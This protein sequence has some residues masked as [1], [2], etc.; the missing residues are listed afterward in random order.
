MN[1]R[2]RRRFHVSTFRRTGLLAIAVMVVLGSS[3]SARADVASSESRLR[4]TLVIDA[5]FGVPTSTSAQAIHLGARLA[6]RDIERSADLDDVA[7]TIRTTD[8][9]G[10]SAIGVDNFIDAAKD[11]SVIAVMG[12]KLSP[13]QIEV[14]A[15]AREQGLMLLDP[16]GAADGVIDNGF[17]PNWAFR[18]SMKDEWASAAFVRAALARG[19]KDVGVILHNS[20]WGRSTQAALTAQ[21]RN[22][23]L[24]IVGERWFNW[25]AVSLVQ[26]YLDLVA[27]GAQLVILVAN[28]QEG[29]LLAR[30]VA[31]L[32]AD[33]RRPILSHWGVTGGDLEKLA[34]DALYVIDFRI[35]QT[36]SF[37]RPRT[38]RATALLSAVL[39]ETGKTS[40]RE[41]E[42]PVGIAQ[43]YD[44]TWLLGMAIHAAGSTDRAK[45][46]AAMENLGPFE[47]AVRTYDQ[48]FTRERHEALSE[49]D[50]FFARYE[51][52]RGLAPLAP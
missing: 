13:V 29:A 41:I 3:A 26:R 16:W 32:P 33:K 17:N 20:T 43:G 39:A 38:A 7:L 40:T 18:L 6:V 50:V 21:A 48:P 44:L 49:S 22:A 25:G 2:F 42:S 51:K 11:P 27:S 52:G 15:I 8:N 45:V 30:E 46:R 31:A 4:A 23:G 37:E 19:F 47:G 5:E 1:A 35:V 10:V 12:G 14:A 9:R 24:R 34:G 36:F 28:E